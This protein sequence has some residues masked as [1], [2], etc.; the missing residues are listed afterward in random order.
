PARGVFGRGRPPQAPTC[1]GRQGHKG[2]RGQ[3]RPRGRGSRRVRSGPKKDPA[4]WR[5]FG[6][7]RFGEEVVW[8]LSLST[9]IYGRD[10]R[11]VWGWT[12]L[13]NSDYSYTT[14]FSSAWSACEPAH[15]QPTLAP[16][17]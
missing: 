9:P 17:R 5:G 16:F 12:N 14:R 1:H 7:G 2:H 15:G 6:G 13:P 8:C 4:Q 11:N 10:R 3:E